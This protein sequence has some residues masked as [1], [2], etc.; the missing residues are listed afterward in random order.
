LNSNTQYSEAIAKI[1]DKLDIV[2]TISEFV[3]LKKAGR[4]YQG[5]CPF[6]KEKT[7]S[8][9]VNPQKQIFKCFGCG[10]AGDAIAFLM[11]ITNQGFTEVISDLAQKFGIELPQ[12]KGGGAQ[13]T[14]IKK[15]VLTANKLAAD[16]FNNGLKTYPQAKKARDYLASRSISDEVIQQYMIGY[17]PNY[18]DE[19]LKFLTKEHGFSV[20]VLEKAGLILQ[21]TNG[22]GHVDRFKNRLMIPI[23]D[24][25]DNIVGFGARALDEGQNPKYLN[26]PDTILYNKSKV[27]FGLN[28]AKEAIRAEDAVI[29]MEGYF[30]VISAQVAGVKNVVAT[31]GT[32]LTQGH[33]KTLSRFMNEKKIYLAFDSDK[34][35]LLATQRGAEVVKE[36]FEGLGEIRQCD[37]SYSKTGDFACEI[38]VV[39]SPQGKDPDEFIKSQGVQAYK[40]LIEKAPLL[41]DFEIDS[42]IKKGDDNLSPQE[43]A[44]KIKEVVKVLSEVKNKII[45]TEYIKAVAEILQVSQIAVKSELEG[46]RPTAISTKQTTL[47]NVTITSNKL[48]IAQKKLLSVYFIDGS[49]LSTLNNCLDEVEFT[50]GTLSQIKKTLKEVSNQVENAEQLQKSLINHFVGEIQAQQDIIEIADYSNEIKNLGETLIK[51]YIEETILFIKRYQSNKM[52]NELKSRYYEAKD[53]ET[54]SLQIQY[55]VRDKLKQV[56]RLK[57]GDIHEQKI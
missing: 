23:L 25:N 45:Q 16:F 39:M 32:S 56:T 40:D 52:Q 13:N 2:E 11:K 37:E 6:H 47:S 10:A 44:K 42:I 9:S 38:R 7:P 50:E 4:N 51:Q 19:L 33:L 57:L 8:F 5:L 21:R 24:E 54:S 18:P 29:I 46:Y 36:A 30:D 48:E 14:E 1:K 28:K 43:K 31:S 35:G 34:A 26:S 20:D 12:F 55:E 27:M 15:Q 22:S 17:S 3:I 41:I 53:D 49:N